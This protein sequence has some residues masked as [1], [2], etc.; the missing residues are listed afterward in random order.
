[1]KGRLL[2]GIV[3]AAITPF[4]QK[5]NLDREAVKTFCD[6]QIAKGCHGLFA[7]G[8]T[9]EFPLMTIEERKQTAEVYVE[10]VDYRVPFAVHVGSTRIE[11]AVELTRH[12]SELKV[13]GVM[14]V[15]PYYYP[16]DDECLFEYFTTLA[17]VDP[18][19]PFYVYNFPASA[20]NDVTPKLIKRLHEACPNIV[21]VKDTSQDYLRFVDYIDILGKDFYN[22]M[23]SDA[24]VLAA[25]VMG[26]KGAVSATAAS[27]PELMVEIYNSYQ[28]GNLVQSQKLQLLASRLRIVFNKPPFLAPRKLALQMRGFDFS[29][30]RQSLRVMTE[31]EI[32][33]F[34]NEIAKLE[35]EFEFELT[36]GIL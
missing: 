5:G 11:E 13:D 14:A 29:F 21:G 16:F 36:S 27:F 22:L 8:S 15:P 2:E 19:L 1:M 3:T 26:G 4:D 17:K 33:T 34:K 35:E 9:G 32:N 12:A 31:Q 10:A 18:E 20:K 25:L 6:F 30:V 23:G 24:M 7:V 28:A